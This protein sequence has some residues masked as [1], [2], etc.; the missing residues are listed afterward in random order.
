MISNCL[1]TWQD[2][3]GNDQ[4]DDG[5]LFGWHGIG[6]YRVG[7]LTAS[8]LVQYEWKTVNINMSSY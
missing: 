4:I 5:D 6:E 2:N 7:S 1:G 3:N 8:N